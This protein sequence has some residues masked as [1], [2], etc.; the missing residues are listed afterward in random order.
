MLS[1]S[2]MFPVA[3]RLER[4]SVTALLGLVATLALTT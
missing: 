4:M 1:A 2:T 3:F